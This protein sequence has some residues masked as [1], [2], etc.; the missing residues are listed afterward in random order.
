MGPIKNGYEI[1]SAGVEQICQR[2]GMQAVDI[3]L[4]ASEQ[5]NWDTP[6]G[7]K[8]IVVSPPPL[9][10][11]PIAV[12]AQYFV[13]GTNVG[14]DQCTPGPGALANAIAGCIPAPNA[15]E[16]DF[17][18]AVAGAYRMDINFAA[19]DSRPV[20]VILNGQVIRDQ[21]VSETT[22]GW[23]NSNLRWAEVGR[24]VL[25][26]GAN[27]VRLERNGVFPHIHDLLFVP[28]PE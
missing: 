28:V 6:R 25:K 10:K 8:Q 20:K 17:V 15:A 14:I 11:N 1:T 22:G 19:A 16:F 7:L 21:A 12:R 9:P 23:S 27:T 24:V 4:S 26:E 2:S 3:S 18:V 5:V 13:R